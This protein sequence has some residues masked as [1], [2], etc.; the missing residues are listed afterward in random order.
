MANLFRGASTTEAPADDKNSAGNLSVGQIPLQGWL[1]APAT[2]RIVDALTAGGAEMRFVG[3]CLRDSLL[4]R[5]TE[6]IDIATPEPPEAVMALL[7]AAEIKALPTGIAHGTVTA[8]VEGRRFEITT[9]RRDVE[10]FGRRAHVSFTDDWL[11]DAKRRDFTFNALSATP[12]GRIFDPFNGIADLSAG[13]VRFIGRAE[14]RIDE[15]AL[16]ILRFF[17]FFAW[18]GHPPV[19]GDAL[20]ACRLKAESLTTLSGE[21]IW[22][23]MEKLLRA[24]DPAATLVLML[25]EHVLTPILPEAG[26]FGALRQLT[27]LET[28]G[29]IRETIAADSLRR[30]AILID[31]GRDAAQA[32]A[33][34]FRLSKRQ[35]DRLTT[36]VDPPCAIGPNLDLRQARRL[37]HR[38]GADRF[39]DLLLLNWAR[40]RAGGT[41]REIAGESGVWHGLLDHA[42][43]WTPRTLPVGGRDMILLGHAPGPALGALLAALESWWIEED[44]EPGRDR[45]LEKARD[46]ARMP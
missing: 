15:D 27:F 40:R 20:Q 23:E 7:G 26:N 19:D 16:R 29:L 10:T 4:G 2:R 43:S 13:W 39:R 45:I 38:L 9:L 12:D 25:G 32:V 44:F 28:R 1:T 6:D 8:I 21:R 18:V 14:Q 35:T 22:A 30:L 41:R 3:G 37:L 11:E 36:L 31:G 46:M 34:R 33:K 42:D 5:E 17:R 24:P